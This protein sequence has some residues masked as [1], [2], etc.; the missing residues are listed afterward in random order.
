[1]PA[2]LSISLLL[3]GTAIVLRAVVAM[4]RVAHAGR[5]RSSQRRMER[6]LKAAVRSRMATNGKRLGFEGQGTVN[7]VGANEAYPCASPAPREL[8]LPRRSTQ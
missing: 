8:I 3:G 7:P 6:E 5:E 1:M 2:W 4:R